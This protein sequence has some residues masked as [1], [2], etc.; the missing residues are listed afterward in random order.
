MSDEQITATGSGEI[1]RVLLIDDNRGDV[2]RIQT[3]L[4]DAGNGTF[5]LECVNRLAAG[6]ERLARGEV[7]V[8]VSDLRLP[9]SSGL[10]TYERLRTQAPF[11]PVVLLSRCTEE[12]ALAL[13]VVRR[14]AQDYLEKSQID[15]KLLSRA[16]YYAIERKRQELMKNEFVSL[17]SHELRTPLTIMREGVSQVMEGICGAVTQEQTQVL[18]IILKNLDR[19]G[20]ILNALLDISKLEAGK[21]KLEKDLVDFAILA[22]EVVAA[23]SRRAKEKGVALRGN[24]PPHPVEIYVD[25]DKIVQVLT[26]LVNNALKFTDR[27][28]IEVTLVDKS[29]TLECRVVDTGCGICAEE[30]PKVFSKFHQFGRV[31]HSAVEKGTGLGLAISKGIVELHGGRIRV[32]SE[33]GRGSSFSFVL[34]RYTPQEVFHEYVREALSQAVQQSE[35]LSVVAFNVENYAELQRQWG[36]Q[37]AG[38]WLKQL[39][40]LIRQ[41]LRRKADVSLMSSQAILVLLTGTA[42]EDARRVADRIRSAYAEELLKQGMYKAV[43]IGCELASFPEDGSSAEPLLAKMAGVAGSRSVLLLVEDE[44]D[45]AELIQSRLKANGFEVHWACDGEEGLRKALEKRP[46]LI[47]MDIVIPKGNGLEICR[48]LKSDAKLKSIPVILM[49]AFD[50][51]NFD[52]QCRAAG[53]DAWLKRP[54]NPADLIELI[55][56]LTLRPLPFDVSE[57]ARLQ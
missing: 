39:R 1:T 56:N 43:Q 33:M 27:G 2:E 40:E 32:E 25:H 11:V 5:R 57:Q 29:N 54:Y 55:Q 3:L 22:S 46:A 6:L 37:K 47:L 28:E 21:L 19:L 17:V 23:F 18:S 9:D 44:P 53:A 48:R 10:E 42:R 31:D 34:P 4:A 52:R 41:N 30:L 12:R 38:V 7:D 49:T 24:F 45:Q 20:R 16:L 51:E 8:V 36:P 35:P 14:G 15:G 13:E 50:V 26:N